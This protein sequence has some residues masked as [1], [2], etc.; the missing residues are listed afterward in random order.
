MSFCNSLINITIMS[1]SVM[2]VAPPAVLAVPGPRGHFRPGSGLALFLNNR[3][4]LTA[5]DRHGMRSWQVTS[6]HYAT[7]LNFHV[8]H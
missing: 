4:E 1:Y 3:G 6:C 7:E 2:Q 5:F 8:D